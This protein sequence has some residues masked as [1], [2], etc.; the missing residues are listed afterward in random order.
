MK[1]LHTKFTHSIAPLTKHIDQGKT[2]ETPW[3]SGFISLVS[4]TELYE[5][6][7]A[8]RNDLGHL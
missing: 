4:L 2:V 7:A 6:L 1:F 8:K 5:H 3:S